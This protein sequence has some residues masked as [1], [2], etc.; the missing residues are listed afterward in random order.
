MCMAGSNRFVSVPATITHRCILMD[1]ETNDLS[2]KLTKIKEVWSALTST[3][4]STTTSPVDGS[5][6]SSGSHRGIL[7]VPS[8]SDVKQ[9]VGMLNFFG[10]KECKDLQAL[11][12]LTSV[13]PTAGAAHTKKD[14][15]SSGSR[16]LIENA[17]NDDDEDDSDSRDHGSNSSGSGKAVS[18][19]PDRPDM[20]T[21]AQQNRL[22]STSLITPI[23]DPDTSPT[24]E[25]HNSD[26]PLNT[27][28]LFV[29]P[30]SGTRGL[31]LQD[32]EYVFITHAPKT[33]DEYLHMAGECIVYIY[34][35]VILHIYVSYT[36]YII[37]FLCT[38]LSHCIVYQHMH[39]LYI[40]TYCILRRSHWSIR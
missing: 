2:Q 14:G 35:H 40:Q 33:M 15:S 32:I 9:T 28:E 25:G 3:T 27:N 4:T 12:G 18:T 8:S 1:C 39:I 10:V 22:G 13:K 31:H 5:D 24:T 21:L 26:H 7:F 29:A 37:L 23:H 6:S 17:D 30:V 16:K 19:R 38:Y 11:L 20:I 36:T 34:V